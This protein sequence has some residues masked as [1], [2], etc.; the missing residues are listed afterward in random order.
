MLPFGCHVCSRAT[1]S[2][3]LCWQR[4]GTQRGIGAGTHGKRQLLSLLPGKLHQPRWHQPDGANW[5]KGMT[6][7]KR[8]RVLR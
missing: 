5:H 2:R 8:Y 1:C 6:A 3:A 4:R 7:D